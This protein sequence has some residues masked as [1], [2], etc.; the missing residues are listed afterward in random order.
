MVTPGRSTARAA[1][2]SA[3]VAA[4]LA[5]VSAV[6][7]CSS[8]SPEVP[9]SSSPPA[10][11][12]S[13]TAVGTSAEL[14]NALDSATAGDVLV[15]TDGRYEGSFTIRSQGSP[16]EPITLCGG[17]GAVLDGGPVDSG[18]TLHLDGASNWRLEG[19]SVIGGQKGV[20]LDAS[21]HNELT[22][23]AVSA[24]GDEGVHL[25]TG[26]SDNLLAGVSV[27]N[28]GLRRPD[29]GE[30]V[31]IGSAES[32]WCDLT[33]CAPDASDHNRLVGAT[34]SGTTAEAI[35]VKEGTTGG[36]LSGNT[37]DGAAITEADSLI[38]VKGTGWRITGNTGT[39]APGDGAQV[40]VIVEGSGS[41]NVFSAN[42]FAVAADGYGVQLAGDARSA[43]NTVS[44][45]N[46][47]TVDGV[48]EPAFVTNIACTR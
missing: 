8:P 27:S 12:P 4:S 7:G 26:S 16:D 1:R 18:Y 9:T 41:A 3:V 40:H 21:S 2:L 14:Q 45:D 43:G 5:L 39:A 30:G 47:A 13:G 33:A 48:A 19:F 36:E 38:D 28:T 20:M 29:F 35:D 46:V 37:L 42:T 24:V 11:C 31:Y 15:L 23:L 34:I 25:R 44:C 22:G 17:P 6:S 32:N 10:A